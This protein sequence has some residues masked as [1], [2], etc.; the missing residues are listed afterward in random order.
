MNTT[1]NSISVERALEEAGILEGEYKK[2]SPAMQNLTARALEAFGWA[3]KSDSG[4]WIPKFPSSYDYCGP[5]ND[6]KIDNG[7]RERGGDSKP[8]IHVYANP[9][10]ECPYVYEILEELPYGETV[11]KIVARSPEAKPPNNYNSITIEHCHD[12]TLDIG[13]LCIASVINL[14]ETGKPRGY[15]LNITL[16]VPEINAAP[17]LDFY[18]NYLC[19]ALE[20]GS[21]LDLITPALAMARLASSLTVKCTKADTLDPSLEKLAYA[22]NGG[23]KRNG[24]ITIAEG[25]RITVPRFTALEKEVEKMKSPEDRRACA[26]RYLLKDHLG[27]K[28]KE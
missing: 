7:G 5:F 27:I 16:D 12:S 11:Q 21:Y 10:S 13:P 6:L 9:L 1:I 22:D 20:G 17:V 18:Y 4:Q 15:W 28:T 2:H 26:L 23:D 25:E 14:Y 3:K 8:A 19:E 24:S